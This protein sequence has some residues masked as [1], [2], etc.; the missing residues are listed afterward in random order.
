MK[1]AT[2]DALCMRFNPNRSFNRALRPM[3]APRCTCK[4]RD[5]D[6]LVARLRDARVSTAG[7]GA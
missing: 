5:I 4:P 1:T 6:T 3:P 7:A 2:L